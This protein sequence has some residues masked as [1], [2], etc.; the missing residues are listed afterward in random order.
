MKHHSNHSGLLD[1]L[2]R[3]GIFS[4]Q[5]ADRI[6]MPDVYRVAF[7]LGRRGGIPPMRPISR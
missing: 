7:G 3:L 1:D 5:K 4:A 6:Q 2:I